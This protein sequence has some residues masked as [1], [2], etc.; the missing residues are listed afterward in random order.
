MGDALV[1]CIAAVV[2]GG[3]VWMGGDSA[4]TDA[5]WRLVIRADEKVF[6]NGPMLIG[7]AGSFRLGQVLRYIFEPPKHPRNCDAPR[8]M[9]Q[10]FVEVLRETMKA[11]GVATKDNNAEEMPDSAFLVGYRGRIFMVDE[12]FHVAEAIDGFASVGCG[13][14]VALGA[15]CVS[16][17]PPRQRIRAALEA[18]ERYHAGVRR[19][20]RIQALEV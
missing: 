14:Q 7:F 8:Y 20:F 11:A 3:T 12:D 18:A 16:D 2:E 15:L 6:R 13:S 17:G 10:H 9:V 1:T 19:P 4:A 5:G